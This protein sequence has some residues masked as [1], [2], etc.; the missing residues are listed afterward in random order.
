MRGTAVWL[1]TRLG[2]TT[3]SAARAASLPAGAA[4]GTFAQGRG[5][6]V[7]LHPRGLANLHP[8]HPRQVFLGGLALDGCQLLHPAHLG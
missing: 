7:L 6:R 5:A 8:A 2:G 4:S 3:R 1:L